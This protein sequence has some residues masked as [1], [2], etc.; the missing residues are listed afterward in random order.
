MLQQYK[1]TTKIRQLSL[2][3]TDDGSRQGFF[4]NVGGKKNKNK[5]SLPADVGGKKNKTGQIDRFSVKMNFFRGKMD[6]SSK[7]N[8]ASRRKKLKK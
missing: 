5:I 8:T 6:R 1:V 2:Y 3:S 7:V 4:L